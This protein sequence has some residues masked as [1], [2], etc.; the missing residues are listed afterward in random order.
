MDARHADR[1]G[2]VA[3][4][5]WLA[6]SD[7]PQ[8]EL[9]L[10][11]VLYTAAVH[12]PRRV[13]AF[14]LV[15]V[16]VVAALLV[17]EGWSSSLAAHIAGRLIVWCALGLIAMV[18]VARVRNQRLGLL[19]ERHQASAL[20]R[21]DALTGLGNRRAFDEA[22][23]AAIERASRGDRPLSVIV[24]DVDSFKRINDQC[25]PAAPRPTATR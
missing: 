1:A 8:Q 20:A 16:A 4:L 17:Y 6:G 19:R 5:V 7:A 18:F 2:L 24:A 10:L 25:A 23:D 12:P 15:L 21:S 22:L 13:V 14:G 9:F 3:V 11:S